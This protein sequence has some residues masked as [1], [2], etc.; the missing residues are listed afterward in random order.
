M[1][2]AEQGVLLETSLYPLEMVEQEA[3]AVEALLTV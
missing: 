3:V 1:V 2:E